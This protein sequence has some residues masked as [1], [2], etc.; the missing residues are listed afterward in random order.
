M[1][2]QTR[3]R[4][5]EET[6]PEET[7]QPSL[8]GFLFNPEVE[9]TVTSRLVEVNDE[10]RAAAAGAIALYRKDSSAWLKLGPVPTG[11]ITLPDGTSKALDNKELE[12]FFEAFLTPVKVAG[13]QAGYIIRKGTSQNPRVLRYHVTGPVKASG[14]G[15]DNE[16]PAAPAETPPE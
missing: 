8:A 3:T 13:N 15:T 7:V 14:S 1:A 6:A 10:H 16:T 5:P 12:T 9:V 4:K 11:A 2:T